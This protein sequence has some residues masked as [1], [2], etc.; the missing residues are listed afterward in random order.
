MLSVPVVAGPTVRI[1]LTDAWSAFDASSATLADDLAL[2]VVDGQ[3]R[4]LVD[5][6][7]AAWGL[8]D[9]DYS[10]DLAALADLAALVR[11]A[12]ESTPDEVVSIAAVDVLSPDL[13]PTT[14]VVTTWVVDLKG[15]ELLGTEIAA[16]LVDSLPEEVHDL[17]QAED[18]ISGGSA[19]TLISLVPDVEVEEQVAIAVARPIDGWAVF[20]AGRARG[21]QS[22]VLPQILEL[23]AIGT[24][25]T[26]PEGTDR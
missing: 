15:D 4:Y 12:V 5:E 26:P 9:P 6:P 1:P 11:G 22:R 17:L 3:Q 8:D 25:A 19:V 7:G 20:F 18:L 14:Q 16:E 2:L 10:W 24:T 23:I 13:P 21:P